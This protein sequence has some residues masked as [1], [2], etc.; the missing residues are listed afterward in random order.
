M[1]EHSVAVASWWNPVDVTTWEDYAPESRGPRRPKLWV[2]DRDGTI[3]LRKSPPPP[4]PT[5]PHTARRCEPAIE[6]LALE[7]ARRVE[8]PTSFARPATWGSDQRGVVSERFHAS[9]EEHHPGAELLGLPEESASSPE[10]KQRR[11]AGRASAT[12][13]RVLEKLTELG[14]SYSADLLRPFA[15]MLVVDAWLGNG[16]R[17]SGNWALVTGS[18]GARLAPMY[19]PAAC[20]GVELT[21]DRPELLDPS[22]ERIKRYVERCPT[23]FGGGVTDG[24]TG[25][26]MV[27]LVE[28][29][30]R[31]P[32]WQDAVSELKPQLEAVTR[33]AEGIID[34]IPDEWLSPGRK[35]FAAIVLGRRVTLFP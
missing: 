16:D 25:I 11:D 18:R 8:V 34:A 20:L 33:E 17:H 21:D 7:L 4:D 2:K 3:W 23:G 31:W 30:A 32:I 10:A 22:E 13:D 29:L 19:D 28:K 5:R 24:R 9:D 12:L 1:L 14:R 27:E 6:V 15:R 35:R 26:P